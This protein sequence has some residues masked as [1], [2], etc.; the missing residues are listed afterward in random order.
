MCWIGLL[1]RLDSRGL[2]GI[3]DGTPGPQSTAH[4]CL[5]VV[6]ILLRLLRCMLR[7]WRDGNRSTGPAGWH[8]L[9]LRLL[10]LLW[11]PWLLKRVAGVG[12]VIL[13]VLRIDWRDLLGLL[14]VVH[15]RDGLCASLST[16]I[17]VLVC[18]RRV[19]RLRVR[20]LVMPVTRHQEG[21]ELK[22]NKASLRGGE[23]K[24]SSFSARKNHE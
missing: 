4:I 21:Q 20:W 9:R 2:L 10:G 22:C 18:L 3:I 8:S 6:Q 17:M 16:R 15:G 24:T 7:E 11:L 12:L 5:L 1:P 14:V 13:E 19:V 23:P